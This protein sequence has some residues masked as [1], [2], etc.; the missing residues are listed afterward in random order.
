LFS[1]CIDFPLLGD[2]DKVAYLANP[3]HP[4][5]GDRYYNY[6]SN[7]SLGRESFGRS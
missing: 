4:L 6:L 1:L 7:A 5:W 2:R 3:Y